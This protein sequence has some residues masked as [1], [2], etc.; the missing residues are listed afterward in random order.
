[1]KFKFLM[2]ILFINSVLQAA[3]I[4]NFVNYEQIGTGEYLLDLDENGV[5]DFNFSIRNNFPQQGFTYRII[6]LELGNEIDEQGGLLGYNVGFD[7][8]WNDTAIM[9]LG[10]LTKFY[11]LQ[12]LINN[13][14]HY[15]WV[16]VKLSTNKTFEI[17]KYAYNDE[18]GGTILMAQSQI[19]SINDNHLANTISIHQGIGSIN[20]SMDDVLPSAVEVDVYNQVGQLMMTDKMDNYAKEISTAFLDNGIY[21]VSVSSKGK[22]LASKRVMVWR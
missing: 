7:A 22:Y 5:N 10:N 12:F 3:I 1:V 18:V 6:G 4:T 19:S 16:E 21:I 13:E 9:P 17:V 2:T 20:I 8:A 11:G 14:T 15:G